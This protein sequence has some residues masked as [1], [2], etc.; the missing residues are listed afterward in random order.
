MSAVGIKCTAVA[1][2]HEEL[3][4]REPSDRASE[5]GAIYGEDLE[6]FAGHPAHPAWNS[7]GLAV[8]WLPVGVYI[9]AQSGLVFGIVSHIAE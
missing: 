4:F 6:R 3:G 8:P 1:W 5:V 7:R 2:T 9:L